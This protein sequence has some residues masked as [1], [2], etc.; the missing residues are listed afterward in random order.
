MRLE[1]MN[2]EFD[3]ICGRTFGEKKA[4]VVRVKDDPV[5]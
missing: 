3:V 1:S 2:C 4:R 5:F